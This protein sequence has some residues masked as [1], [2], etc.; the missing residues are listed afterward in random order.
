MGIKVDL[1]TC[2]ALPGSGS[3]MLDLPEGVETVGNLLE[4]M[5]VQIGF[6]FIDLNTGEL[7]E[8]LEIIL[9]G[10]EVWFYASALDTNLNDG[11]TVEIYLLPLGGG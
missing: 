10:K 9:N 7:E 8:D 3:G 6:N 4:H 1:K 5:G 2:F 11:D